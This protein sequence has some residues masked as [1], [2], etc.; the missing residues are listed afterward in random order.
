[1]SLRETLLTPPESA[2]RGFSRG[3]RRGTRAQAAPTAP[4]GA[5]Q[6]SPPAARRPGTRE[7]KP[8]P[9]HPRPPSPSP[10]KRPAHRAV[11]GA[12]APARTEPPAG[13]VP[14]P[15]PGRPR[16]SPCAS[17]LARL[18]RVWLLGRSCCPGRGGSSAPQ[19]RP[20]WPAS[21]RAGPPPLPT[22]PLPAEQAGRAPGPAGCKG[23]PPDPGEGGWDPEGR[24][25]PQ[26]PGPGGWSRSPSSPKTCGG[27]GGGE[28]V[29]RKGES[30]KHVVRLPACFNGVYLFFCLNCRL[31][32]P[33]CTD[34]MY[35]F[36]QNQSRPK[37]CTVTCVGGGALSS[38][39]RP[40]VSCSHVLGF[41]NW[42]GGTPLSH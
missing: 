37:K 36:S 1:M 8:R 3:Q 42:D 24:P 20:A 23:H 28:K 25:P 40:Q 15:G 19:I 10:A 18:L 34:L 5:L 9:R 21:L 32:H 41:L 39:L 26:P 33:F 17:T 31:S 29:G 38:F 27:L 11:P 13:R 14:V 7:A 30:A 22:R 4:L 12:L 35:P 6:P 16:H 2:S